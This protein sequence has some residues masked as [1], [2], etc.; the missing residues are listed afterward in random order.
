MKNK[1]TIFTI[2]LII[3][4]ISAGGL[5]Y[6]Q[7]QTSNN[8]EIFQEEESGGEVVIGGDEDFSNAEKWPEREYSEEDYEGWKTF[9]HEELGYEIMYP[10]N[11]GV[12]DYGDQHLDREV[13]IMPG[14]SEDFVN[15]VIIHVDSR[16]DKDYIALS[17]K[18]LTDPSLYGD[19]G[20]NCEKKII[21]NGY[22]SYLFY[23]NTDLMQ[24]RS[25]LIPHNNLLYSISTQKHNIPEV[26]QI[27]SSFKF[28]K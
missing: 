4:A 25:I 1:K 10:N 3:L 15:Y 17:R 11:W 6:F 8:Q 18:V 27:F 5:W 14:D 12:I 22:N 19:S 13:H 7:N 26:P 16:H 28:V 21:L 2:S 20:P 24:S 23:R 9:I